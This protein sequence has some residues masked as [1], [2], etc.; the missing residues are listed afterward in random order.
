MCSEASLIILFSASVCPVVAI[1]SGRL[2]KTAYAVSSGVA[3]WLEKSTMTSASPENS[4]R[5]EYSFFS[6]A[7]LSTLVEKERQAYEFR[8]QMIEKMKSE[9][10]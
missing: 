6:G 8:L 3:A 10:E 9:I 4:E 5:A 2:C 1:T 7:V